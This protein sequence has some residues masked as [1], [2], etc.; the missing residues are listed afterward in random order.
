MSTTSTTRLMVLAA[1]LA[2]AAMAGSRASFAANEI[3]N[4]QIT[5]VVT[6]PLPGGIS[7]IHARLRAVA[8]TW[9]LHLKQLM[10]RHAVPTTATSV[11][12]DSVARQGDPVRG[13]LPIT[14][15]SSGWFDAPPAQASSAGAS[16][17]AC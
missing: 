14:P 17:N 5:D 13:D 12:T 7:S 1:V 4:P 3:V 9:E 16:P 10:H 2:L 8:G 6:T 11:T 15:C